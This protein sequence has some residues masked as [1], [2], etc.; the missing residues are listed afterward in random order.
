MEGICKEQ[1]K[2]G[3]LR[4]IFNNEFNST[5]TPEIIDLLSK[6]K[7]VKF[8]NRFNQPVDNLPDSLEWI[9]FSVDFNQ[10]VDK[11]PNSLKSISW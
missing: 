10:S 8:G 2:D 11:L 1:I 4:I 9:M 6:Y 5:L 7:R 3:H